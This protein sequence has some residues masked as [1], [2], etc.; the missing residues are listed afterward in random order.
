MS[1]RRTH[2]LRAGVMSWA[3]ALAGA[4]ALSC[5]EEEQPGSLMLAISTDMYVDKD[6]SRVDIVVQPERG[7]TQSA[8]INLFPG[9]E[10]QFL[11]GT[12]ST[13]ASRLSRVPNS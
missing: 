2:S 12:F 3:L 7:P 9:L 6:V 10:G 11:P 13:F 4:A 5:G 1:E 8:Q